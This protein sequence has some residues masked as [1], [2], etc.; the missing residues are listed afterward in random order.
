MKKLLLFL[1]I[2]TAIFSLSMR[3]KQPNPNLSSA[4]K[5]VEGLYVGNIKSL[6]SFLQAYPIYFY[7]SSYE[8][9]A[10]K[11]RELAYYFKRAAGLMIALDRENYYK[12]LVSPFQFE[13]SDR[14]GFFSFIPNHWLFT[15]PIGNEPDSVAGKFSKQDT[16]SQVAFIK[17]A[18]GIFRKVIQEMN[19]NNHFSKLGPSDVFHALRLDMFRISTIDIANSD[20][21]IDEAGLSSLRG[22][23]ESWIAYANELVSNLPASSAGLKASWKTICDY[24]IYYLD[25]NKDFL[26]FNRAQFI[27]RY[28]IPLSSMLNDI[29][30]VLGVPYKK[31]WSAIRSDARHIYDRNVFNTDFFAP[32]SN[33]YYSPE[34]AR[35]GE[36]L[37]FDPILSDNNERACASCHKPEKAF[38][39]GEPKATAFEREK[40]LA[41][42]SP[43]VINSGFQKKAFWD[44]RAGSLEDQLDSVINNPDELH[45]SFERIIDRLNSS[46]EYVKLFNQAFPDCK[47][48]GIQRADVKNAIGVYER[49]VVGLN[50][51]FD[52]YMQGDDSKLT[53]EEINGFNVYMG[54]GKCGICHYAPLFNGAFPP[55]FEI[56]DHHSIGVP[57]KDTMEKYVIDPDQGMFKSTGNVYH[58]FSFKTP[59]VRNAALTAPYMHNGVY[60]TLEQVVNFYDHA[61][62]V[63]FGKDYRGTLMGLPFFTILPFELKLTD[64][65]KNDL[66]AFVHA[67]NDTSA[68][69]A[70]ARLPQLKGKYASLNNRKIGGEY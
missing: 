39:D 7:D 37:F 50:S 60:K 46:P 70:P 1:L 41:R 3:K 64:K 67:L 51:R 59:T 11:Y 65:E 24:T 20:L 10:R 16:L 13:K 6:D 43:T 48:Q 5:A 23:I 42:N 19:D 18:T 17:E 22:S 58:R 8:V 14:K 49:T 68:A 36:L 69:K 45:S 32:N 12:K 21:V 55:F 34:K 61:G 4:I 38:T 52:Q 57:V 25:Q 63:K 2:C 56:T 44:Q 66:I 62:G 53:E 47:K 26:A 15:G 29:Q 30:Q 27:R 31:E 40:L 9:R 33:A 54:K 35:L 28:L